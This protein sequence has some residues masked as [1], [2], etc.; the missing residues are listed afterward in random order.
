ML[1]TRTPSRCPRENIATEIDYAPAATHDQ[2]QLITVIY[3]RLH[4]PDKGR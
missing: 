2:A 3:L 4:T 1:E